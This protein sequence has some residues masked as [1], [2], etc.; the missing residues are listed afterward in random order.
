MAE[1]MKRRGLSMMAPKAP[2]GKKPE[3]PA[4]GGEEHGGG[5]EGGEEHGGGEEGGETKTHT[6]TEHPDGH[7]QSQMHGG[8]AM[9]H[10]DH[11]HL[12]AHI[13]HQV[14][15]GDAHHV[16]HHDGM[17]AH[18]HMVHEG[19]EHE[20]GEQNI[21]DVVSEHG[22]AEHVEIHSHH[23]DGHVHKAKHHDSASAREHVSKAFGEEPEHEAEPMPGESGDQI[24]TMA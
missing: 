14:T 2:M 6:I 11:M 12:M 17:E 16:T 18:S 13:G 1:E 24:P 19:G 9:E 8:E 20:D 3:T 5:E 15:G 4:V 22:P 7:F 23:K 21:E 10:P